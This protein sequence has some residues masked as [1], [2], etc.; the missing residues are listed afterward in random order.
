MGRWVRGLNRTPAKGVSL[1]WLRRFES[2]TPLHNAS[3]V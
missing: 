2:D 1:N 3:V